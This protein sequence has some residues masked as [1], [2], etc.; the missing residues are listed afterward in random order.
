MEKN[1]LYTLMDLS[2]RL[3][4]PCN[5]VECILDRFCV[6][7]ALISGDCRHYNIA[8]LKFL[9]GSFN[10]EKQRKKL[11]QAFQERK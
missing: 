5:H 6:K 8:V 1:K 3:E 10:Q 7:P 2:E 9:Q 4:I 11:E